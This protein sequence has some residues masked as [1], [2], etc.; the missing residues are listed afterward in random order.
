MDDVV[1]VEISKSLCD[2]VGDVHLGVVGEGINTHT[3]TYVRTRGRGDT[4]ISVG[5]DTHHALNNV[6]ACLQTHG[7]FCSAYLLL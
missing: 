3:S 4:R 7:P 6:Q 5:C 1:A 2:I